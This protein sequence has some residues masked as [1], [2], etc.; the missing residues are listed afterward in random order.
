MRDDVEVAD[1]IDTVDALTHWET[2]WTLR[3]VGG[4]TPEAY[5]GWLAQ[6]MAAYALA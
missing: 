2:W 6:M 4:W 3:R 5:E 1:L